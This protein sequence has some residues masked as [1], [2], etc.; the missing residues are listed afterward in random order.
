MIGRTVSHYRILEKLGGGGMGVVYKAEDIRLGRQV[1]LKFLPEG[2]SDGSQALER[3][4]REARSASALNHPNICTIHDFDEDEGRQFIV[5]E[6]LEGRTLSDRL[7]GK[8]MAKEE[9]IDLATQVVAGLAAAHAKG[10][11]HRDIKPANI[12]I[13]ES[14]HVKILDFGLAKLLPAWQVA[15]EPAGASG[16]PTEAADRLLTGPGAALGTVAY[17]SPEQALGKELDVRTDLFS[18]GVVLY[19]M[20]AGVLPF[21]GDTSA[22]LV[23]EL[24]HKVPVGPARLN[25]DVPEEL[26]R[27]IAKLL[28]KDREMRYQSVTEFSADLRRL[29]RDS[30][31]GR[32]SGI[33][34][35]VRRPFLARRG[36]LVGATAGVLLPLA[37]G[38][39]LF[40]GHHATIDSVA[41]LPFANLSGD[42]GTDYLSDG[43]SESLINNL[44][45]LPKL[46]VMSWSSVSRYKGRP[47]DVRNAADELKVSAILTGQVVKRG[48]SLAISAE[49]VNAG[50]G[51]NIWGQQYNRKQADIILVQE[52]ISKEILANLRVKLSGEEQKQLNRRP[53]ESAEAYELYLKGR[54]YWN[55]V[56]EDGFRKAINYF[57][58]AVERDPGFALA[59]AGLA[60]SYIQL[61]I[62]FSLPVKETMPKA[63]AYAAKA[64]KLDER[65]AEAH[66]SLGTCSLVYEW[67]WAAA[68]KEFSR[69]QQLNPNYAEAYHFRGHYLEAMGRTDEAIAEIK[70][71]LDLDPVSLFINNELGWAYY[72]A[73][74]YDLAIKQYRKGL[75]VDPRFALSA[76]SLAQVYEQKGM[77]QEA[78]AELGRFKET[79]GQEAPWIAELGCVHALAG[80]RNEALMK[81]KELKELAA[82]EYVDPYFIAI[83]HTALGEKELAFE[84]LEKAFEGRSGYLAWIKVEPKLNSLHADV[85]FRSLLRRMNLPTGGV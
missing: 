6:F 43:I 33:V 84:W 69:A 9:I 70:R 74:Q 76:Y 32:V 21:R 42:P 27:A 22:A 23:D 30:G 61:G 58:Q 18:L 62:D 78:L 41:V 75:E 40:L 57:N 34:P 50:D 72:H 71:G 17:M 13:T 10:I 26:G 73:Q 46:R 20:A 39:W 82:R 5:M 25:P 1:A 48:D 81:L 80:K 51:S 67:D 37:I 16:L 38:L 60:D 8:R 59:Y 15:S 19:E 11:I 68:D 45:Q 35:V 24:L 65:L 64:L 79:Y 77:Y 53:T 31:S 56:T 83:V 36:T 66:V 47:V 63:T 54:F 44:S 14:G 28:E 52:E 4:Q 2:L 3:F 85:R 12:F 7:L 49:L 29:V 55:E